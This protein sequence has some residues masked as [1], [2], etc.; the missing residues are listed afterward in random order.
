MKTIEEL[1]KEQREICARAYFE[2]PDGKPDKTFEDVMNIIINAPE[3]KQVSVEPVVMLP[4]PNPQ[5][6][7]IK[8]VNQFLQEQREISAELFK[9]YCT[10]TKQGG[11]AYE[12]DF[13]LYCTILASE[14]SIVK[15]T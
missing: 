3:P 6:F 4:K 13:N 8:N 2:N 9:K 14:K 10:L 1:L 11:F 7:T 12:D 5:L 15:S